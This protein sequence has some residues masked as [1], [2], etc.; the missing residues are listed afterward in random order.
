M[1][2]GGYKII[3]FKDTPFEVGGA[4]MR[5]EGIYDSIEAS[6]RKSI[7]LSGLVVEGKEVND[8]F[9]A[10]V[11]NE[12]NYEFINAEVGI[13]IIVTDTDAVSITTI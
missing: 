5:I 12:S 7:L 6:Y 10:P 8:I 3:D 11:V 9:A 4:T 2:K 1:I 13:K